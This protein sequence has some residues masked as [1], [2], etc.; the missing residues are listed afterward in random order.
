[1]DELAAE[2][3]TPVELE[4]GTMESDSRP[5]ATSVMVAVSL[6]DNIC[7]YPRE[8]LEKKLGGRVDDKR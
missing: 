7:N 5:G 4:R 6:W 3:R 1:M 2:E 8:I